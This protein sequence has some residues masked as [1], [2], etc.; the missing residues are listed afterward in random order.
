MG[1]TLYPTLI[2]ALVQLFKKA[3]NAP[4]W[5]SHNKSLWHKKEIPLPKCCQMCCGLS[6]ALCD[7][8]V[9]KHIH[10]QQVDSRWLATMICPFVAFI[11][12]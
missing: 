9:A 8:W 4:S 7:F 12:N 2:V 11:A 5:M 1:K 3:T 6:K 10:R